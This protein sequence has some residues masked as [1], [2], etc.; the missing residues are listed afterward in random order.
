[1]ER[2]DYIKDIFVFFCRMSNTNFIVW[3]RIFFKAQL[4]FNFYSK[5]KQKNLWMMNKPVTQ[6]SLG[7]C[8][9]HYIILNLYEFLDQTIRLKCW[10]PHWIELALFQNLYSKNLHIAVEIHCFTTS[11]LVLFWKTEGFLYS[12]EKWTPSRN[13]QKWRHT[14]HQI[15]YF[16]VNDS[17]KGLWNFS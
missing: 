8:D 16:C 3:D 17:R 2:L 4:V 11:V 6:L 15:R 14:D 10:K 7:N 5:I 12:V 13:W 9:Y 1:M